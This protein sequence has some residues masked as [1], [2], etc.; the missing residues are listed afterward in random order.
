[1][2]ETGRQ[3]DVWMRNLRDVAVAYQR[4]DRVVEGSCRDFDLPGGGEFSVLRNY[5]REDFALLAPHQRLI[6]K[7]EIPAFFDQAADF[8]VVLLKLFVE[9]CHLGEHLE[10]A[11]VLWAEIPLR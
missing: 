4:Q 3:R 1:M 11:K 7:G 6:F 2:P 5:E 10:V 9:P 8:G